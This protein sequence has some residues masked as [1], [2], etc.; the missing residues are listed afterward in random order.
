MFW[1][2]EIDSE[3]S[4]K[5]CDLAES[6]GKNGARVIYVEAET[7]HQ[8]CSAA[9]LWHQRYTASKRE[10]CRRY[11]DARLASGKCGACGKEPPKAGCKTCQA[12]ISK[13]NARAKAAKAGLIEVRPRPSP[14]QVLER[15]RERARRHAER[16]RR[17]AYAADVARIERSTRDTYLPVTLLLGKLDELGPEQFRVWLVAIRDGEFHAAAE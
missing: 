8:A 1:R 12:C 15:N 3:G 16:H 4:I 7:K 5:T 14:E 11:S 6:K 10:R 9:K 13:I 17:G 2:V